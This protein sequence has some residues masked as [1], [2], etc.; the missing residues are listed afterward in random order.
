MKK[1]YA[2][3]AM[4]ALVIITGT[5]AHAAE[6]NP[7]R[8]DLVDGEAYRKYEDQIQMQ[9]GNE[10]YT[11]AYMSGLKPAGITINSDGSVTGTPTSA[12]RYT[13]MNVLISHTDGTS[14][15]VT[16]QIFIALRPI[17]VQITAPSNVVYD[18]KPHTAQIKCFDYYTGE[19][20]TQLSPVLTYGMD[21]ITE[22]VDAG[23][24]IIKVRPPSGCSIEES[25]GDTHIEISRR[26]AK[27]SVQDKYCLYTKGQKFGITADDVTVEP[28]GVEYIV[29]YR[30]NGE[31]TYT[32]DEPTEI[33]IYRVRVR[34]TNPNYTEAYDEADLIV[35]A[36]EA[37]MNLGNSPAAMILSEDVADSEKQSN[38][39]AF[40]ANH[41]FG[42]INYPTFNVTGINENLDENEYTVVVSDIN[43][44][45]DPGF[46]IEGLGAVD[47]NKTIEEVTE[48]IYK[49]TYDFDSEEDNLFRY[50]MVVR[51]IGDVDNSGYVNAIDANHFNKVAAGKVPAT[52]AEARVWDVNKDGKLNKEDANAIRNRFSIPLVPY[53]PWVN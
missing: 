18:G 7:V 19:E 52:V 40:K 28:A 21:N 1:L 5:C 45:K 50:V 15:V 35:A 46:F 38:L 42:G 41:V 51:G 30:K 9:G 20:L 16:F 25:E 36:G 3:F 33:G 39:A 11:F 6:F 13:K 31:S 29:E 24:Y 34:I 4:I 23:T 27:I 2:L 10:G 43:K 37:K 53:Y 48:N 12:G 26:I 47:A 17:K 14:A 49:V 44:F 32:T 22:P 8:T